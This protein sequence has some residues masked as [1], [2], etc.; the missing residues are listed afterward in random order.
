MGLKIISHLKNCIFFRS[1]EDS[2]ASNDTELALK[3]AP[4]S[5]RMSGAVYDE[6]PIWYKKLENFEILRN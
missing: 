2:A 4:L 5:A 3:R 6:R 1:G